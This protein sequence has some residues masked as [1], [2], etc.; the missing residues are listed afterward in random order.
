MGNSDRFQAIMAI[1]L[2][3]LAKCV[4]VM[5]EENRSEENFFF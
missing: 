3:G 1:K 5:G 4:D 2:I